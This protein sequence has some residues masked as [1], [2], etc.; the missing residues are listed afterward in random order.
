MIRGLHVCAH[1]RATDQA[2]M[3]RGLHV[4]ARH[5]ATD[6]AGMTNQMVLTGTEGN[7]R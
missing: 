7:G 6:Q 2:G 3:I 1:H 5:R 4:C